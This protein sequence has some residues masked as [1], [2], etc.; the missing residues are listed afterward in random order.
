MNTKR[1]WLRSLQA[2][3]LTLGVLLA[4]LAPMMATAHAASVSGGSLPAGVQISTK[5]ST[6]A[7]PEY[8]KGP[9]G[10][11]Y[12]PQIC[13]WVNKPGYYETN[14]ATAVIGLACQYIMRNPEWI[15]SW[16]VCAGVGEIAAYVP[17][18]SYQVC[19]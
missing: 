11:E 18:E 4:S 9:G 3:A 19:T 12:Y 17:G 15:W 16:A 8:L 14:F 13:Q 2:C 10:Q 6:A 7:N 5:G 1:R